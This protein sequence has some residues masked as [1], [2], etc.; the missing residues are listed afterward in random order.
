MQLDKIIQSRR[1]IRKY[2]PKSPNWRSIIEAIDAARYAPMA[3][4]IFSLKFILVD[5]EEKIKKIA[6]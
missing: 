5:D 3:G 1:S 6:Q 4:N 2:K